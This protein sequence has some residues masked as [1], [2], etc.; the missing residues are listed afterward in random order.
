MKASVIIRTLNESRYL[1]ELLQAIS[2]QKTE[3][4]SHEVII[5]DSGSTD[6]TLKIANEYGCQITY[7]KKEDFSFGRSLNIGCKFCSG[8]YL[9]FISG[10]CIPVNEY[11]LQE[12][13]GPLINGELDYV[14]GKQQGRD[15]TKFSEEL[16][17]E[18][19]YP[20]YSNIPQKDFFCNNANS[21]IKRS[22]WEKYE[23]N[24]NLTGL[25]D[26]DLAKRI[27]QDSYK[28]GYSSKSS[29]YHIHDETWKQLQHRYERES[30]ALKDIM[31][32]I[33]FSY[34]DFIRYF[35]AG[36]FN[37][38]KEAISRGKLHEASNIIKFRY[39][40]YYG[41]YLGNKELRE[42]S[43]DMKERYFYPESKQKSYGKK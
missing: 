9:I 34:L 3:G 25:E 31:P 4:L 8:D 28:V 21:A 1:R 38:F 32:E 14:Y 41:T 13:C 29:V 10:H 6:E 33:S 27:Q 16:L 11:W 5:V 12:L 7:I 43:S 17:F 22:V 2:D 20:D 15:T 42:L 37:D 36:I 26:M 39:N 24:E 35:L 18:K 40:H 23:F 19:F 30:Y